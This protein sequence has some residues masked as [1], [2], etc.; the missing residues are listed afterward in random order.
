MPLKNTSPI[1][2]TLPKIKSPTTE[3]DSTLLTYVKTFCDA[4]K[5]DD[6]EMKNEILAEVKSRMTTSWSP[7]EL[8]PL[9]KHTDI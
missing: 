3:S 1:V 6:Q 9:G 7:I 4:L 5:M 2:G 8:I